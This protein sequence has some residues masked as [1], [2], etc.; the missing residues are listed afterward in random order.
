VTARGHAAGTVLVATKVTLSV[1]TRTLRGRVSASLRSRLVVSSTSGVQT[2]VEV[3]PGAVL[4]DGTKQVLGGRIGVGASVQI[5]GYSEPSGAVRAVSIRIVHPNVNFSA[6]VISNAGKLVVQTSKGERF[7]LYVS[8]GTQVSTG[9]E[10]FT[11]APRDLPIGAKVHI[12]GTVRSDGG[13]RVQ[14]MTIRLASEMVRGQVGQLTGQAMDLQTSSGA[15][16]VVFEP[17]MSVAQGAH[18]L[19][20][21]DLVV[22]DEVTAYGYN[23][24]PGMLL[25]R[26]LLVHRPIA[27]LDG[28]VQTLSTDGFILTTTTGPIHVLVSLS[29]VF[30]TGTSSNLAAGETVHVTG[31][32]RGDGAVLATRI[33]V[34]KLPLK[35][36]A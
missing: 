11:L 30:S 5:R 27:G 22:G 4:T 2:T 6:I 17:Q 32:R 10:Q 14:Q 7:I 34:K 20:T 15:V 23:D 35:P 21:G 33:R 19:T 24:G 25:A 26:K 18:L 13:V 28:T 36:A 8:A 31:Y 16:H 12:R 29:T 9:R 3:P 1:K